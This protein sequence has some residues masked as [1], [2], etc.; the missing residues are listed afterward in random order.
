[1]YKAAPV[2]F[3][4]W[5]ACINI[6]IS[7]RDY[8]IEDVFSEDFLRYCYLLKSTPIEVVTMIWDTDF[9]LNVLPI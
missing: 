8:T 6:L 4:E 3:V 5:L 9:S 2:N 7:D 1:M